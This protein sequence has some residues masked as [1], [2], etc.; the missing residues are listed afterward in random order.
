[1]TIGRSY[2]KLKP[3]VTM[4]QAFRAKAELM[5]LQELVR[6]VLDVSGYFHQLEISEEEDAQD[7][8]ENIEELISKV[9][10]YEE[11]NDKPM[12]G[13]FLEEVALVSDLDKVDEKE[14]RVLL[15]TFHSAKGLEFPRVY[16]TGME[17][18]VFPGYMTITSDDP[19]EME[20]ERRLA[21]VGITRAKKYLSISCARQRM[22]HGETQ[23]NKVSRFVN[24][25]PSEL[26]DQKLP[27]SKSREEKMETEFGFPLEGGDSGFGGSPY[28]RTYDSRPKAIYKKLG[29]PENRKPYISKGL[30]SLQNI[31]GLQKGTASP[32]GK[33]NYEV[34]DLVSHI[35]FGK[36]I[37]K[38]IE[39]KPRDFE[40]SVDFGEV[41]TRILLASFAKLKKE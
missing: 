21:Y 1:M 36:G 35:K 18:G 37:V 27:N 14:E 26:L 10:S 29:T 7:R 12:L 23:Y 6:D 39:K 34:G 28:K 30:G 32:M 22:I 8:I 11:T 31:N 9:V 2:L 40:V 19:T 3:F 41:G 5:S 4:I 25:I 15:M 33:P 13:E 24:E 20:E 16:L 38:N 17:D